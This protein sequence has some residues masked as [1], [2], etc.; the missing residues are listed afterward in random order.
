MNYKTV[1]LKKTEH[2]YLTDENKRSLMETARQIQI[3]G[4]PRLGEK[5][6]LTIIVF[7]PKS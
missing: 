5:M 3:E 7:H 2:V 1:T 6:H 4:T